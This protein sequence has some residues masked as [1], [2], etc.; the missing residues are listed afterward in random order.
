MMIYENGKLIKTYRISLGKNP[1][2]HKQ[3]EGDERTPEGLYYLNDKNPYSVCH[4][5][6]GISYPRKIDVRSA[7][8]FGKSAGGA[9]KIH[10]IKNG[11]GFLGK[12][13]RFFDW[14]NGCIALTDQEI[15]ELYKVV[16]VGT[17]I[18]I[19]P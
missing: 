17:P 8:K 15:D 7:Q 16:K 19:L 4:K 14:T 11:F 13:H 5:N 12:F 2:G 18:E 9:I 6:F 10:G 3:F 1:K